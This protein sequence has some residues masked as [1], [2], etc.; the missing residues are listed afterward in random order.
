MTENC[1]GCKEDCSNCGS[2]LEI[3]LLFVMH[4]NVAPGEGEGE[5]EGW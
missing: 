2:V 5:G 4:V 3:R 1:C